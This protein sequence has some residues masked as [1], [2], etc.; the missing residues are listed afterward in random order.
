MNNYYK[1]CTLCKVNIQH[2]KNYIRHCKTKLHLQNEEDNI[3]CF[4]CNKRYKTLN[5]YKS[6][7]HKYHQ[8]TKKIKY[9]NSDNNSDNSDG[10]NNSDNNNN[11]NNNNDINNNDINNKIDNKLDN[12]KNDITDVKNN[13]NDVKNNINVVKEEINKSN[14]KVVTVVNKAINKASS[15]IKYLMEH[16]KSVPP[17][18]KITKNQ[19]I[20]ILRLDYKCPEIENDYSLQEIFIKDHHRNLF[21]PNIAKS[22]LKMIHYNNKNKQQIYNTDCSRYNYV[23]KLTPDIWNEDKAGIK[24]TDCIIKPLLRY[25]RELIEDY[26][27]NYLEKINMYKNTAYQNEQ[28]LDEKEKAYTFDIALTNDYLIKPLLKELTPHLRFLEFEL[29]ELEKFEELEKIHEDLQEIINNNSDNNSDNI[30]LDLDSDTDDYN[31]VIKKIKTRL[32]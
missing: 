16:H 7:K 18:K 17:L 24:F 2:E 21:I 13:I 32:I 4:L 6:H 29:K 28:L 14:E 25:I 11:N 23:I 27:D 30:S 10:D 31:D 5:A 9:H 15:L 3:M 8:N 19:C 1:H 22:I 12:I 20:P 26:I